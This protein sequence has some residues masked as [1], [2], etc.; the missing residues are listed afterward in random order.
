MEKTAQIAF[1]K[2]TSLFFTATYAGNFGP[3]EASPSQM[4][5]SKAFVGGNLLIQTPHDPC[6]PS[7][8]TLTA[9]LLRLIWPRIVVYSHMNDIDQGL[10]SITLQR[11]SARHHLIESWMMTTIDPSLYTATSLGTDSQ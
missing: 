2:L 10:S 7:T 4:R 5:Q 1:P 11:Q 9:P 8:A 3:R 6:S